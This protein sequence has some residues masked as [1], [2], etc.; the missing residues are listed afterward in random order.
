MHNPWS[1]GDEMAVDVGRKL[2]QCW[3]R[4]DEVAFNLETK[5]GFV[6]PC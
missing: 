5:E 3:A 1:L 6:V 2:A 4:R